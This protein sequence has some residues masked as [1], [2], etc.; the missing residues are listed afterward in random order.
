MKK[1]LKKTTKIALIIVIIITVA[2]GVL[3]GI[4][5]NQNKE[6]IEIYEE[7]KIRILEN[8]IL[9][10]EYSFSELTA[11]SEE[12]DFDAI[13]KPS[14]KVA[15]EKTYSGIYL[16]DLFVNLDIDLTDKTAVYFT[17]SD[18]LQKVYAIAD[19]LEEGNVYIADKVEGEY[20]NDGIDALAYSKPQE[21]GGPY[22]VIKAKDEVSQDRVKLL[23]EINIK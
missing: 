16:K 22:V 18:G 3:L 11:Y 5:L 1:K 20:F 6:N 17:A 15:L 9:L 13:Y 10:G 12:V 14:G 2:F 19:I 23:V 7:E 21:D 8:D 4:Y